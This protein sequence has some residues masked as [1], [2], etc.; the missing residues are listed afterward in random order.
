M[1]EAGFGYLGAGEHAGY[2]LGTGVVVEGADL[3]LGA[4]LG[5]ALLY[6]QMLVCEGGDLREVGA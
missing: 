2:F 4:T 5:F 3:G 6:N 1:L